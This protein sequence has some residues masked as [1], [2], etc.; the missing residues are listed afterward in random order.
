MEI[1]NTSNCIKHNALADACSVMI[2]MIFTPKQNNV[3][4]GFGRVDGRQE[5]IG[6]SLVLCVVKT[7]L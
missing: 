4:S 2:K 3:G 6:M 5:D 7:Y 1:L